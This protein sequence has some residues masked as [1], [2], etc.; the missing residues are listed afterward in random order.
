VWIGS[1]HTLLRLDAAS[2][3]ILTRLTAP[4][5]VA[6]SD[7]A[8]DPDHSYLYVS[9]AHV[10]KGGCEGNA[11]VEYGARSGEPERVTAAGHAQDQSIR[12]AGI[13]GEVLPEHRPVDETLPEA[14]SHLPC[15]GAGVCRICPVG[16]IIV[17]PVLGRF[18]YYPERVHAPVLTAQPEGELIPG[19]DLLTKVSD[20]P[21]GNFIA[22]TKRIKE[23]VPARIGLK[24][25]MP[26]SLHPSGNSKRIYV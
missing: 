2:G 18:S 19:G 4:G 13:F 5:G 15:R 14:D 7:I 17:R 25:P 9:V 20:T 24:N 3:A 12:E 22:V 23:P 11:L 10:V 8:V 26:H 1:F 6:V 16:I 21:R